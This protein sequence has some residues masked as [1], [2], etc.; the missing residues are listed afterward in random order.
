MCE[1]D[2][3]LVKQAIEHYDRM[4]AWAK[5]RRNEEDIR[6][7]MGKWIMYSDIGENWRGNYCPLCQKYGD[8]DCIGC[9]IF[10]KT[11]FTNCD[12]TPWQKLNYALLWSTWLKYAKQERKFLQ[13][14]LK[15]GRDA[16]STP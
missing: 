15:E 7:S 10:E 9:P 2:V 3:G 12:N 4:I 8:K 6:Y 14:L 13:S 5:K 1:E 11:E 16:P